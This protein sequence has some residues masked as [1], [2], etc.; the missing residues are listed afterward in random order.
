VLLTSIPS[1]FFGLV[2]GAGAGL[3]PPV[4]GA[5]LIASSLAAL[6]SLSAAI[7]LFAPSVG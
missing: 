7:Y 6:A 1:G 2:F 3:R 5:T 4:A